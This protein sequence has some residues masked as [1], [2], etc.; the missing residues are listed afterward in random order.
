MEY[1]VQGPRPRGR[2]KRTWREVVR[3]DCQARRMNKEDAMD[4]CKWRKMLEDV[5]WSGWAW[6]GKCFFWYRPTRF[7]IRVQHFSD[8]ATFPLIFAFYAIFLESVTHVCKVSS[9]QLAKIWLKLH[10]S[11]TAGK[12]IVKTCTV[13]R[14]GKELNKCIRSKSLHPFVQRLLVP[15]V[16]Q[17]VAKPQVLTRSQQNCSKQEERRYWT[18]CTEY[19][20]RS[21]KLVSGQR[22]GRSPRSSHFPGKV[23]WNSVPITEQLLLSPMQARSFFG[24]YWKGSKWR[25]TE[26]TD[27]QVGLR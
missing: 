27:E 15:S 13:M 14:K 26:I 12:V 23:I 17:Q 10:K 9:Q 6:V 11:Q 4:R 7:P 21:G 5:R 18:E 22:N 25:Q 2:P 16:R 24:S 19:V 20:W 1:E 8:L 3:E